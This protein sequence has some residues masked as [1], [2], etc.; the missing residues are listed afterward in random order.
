MSI[1]DRWMTALS[2]LDNADRLLGEVRIHGNRGPV[3]E[4]LAE[5]RAR[6]AAARQHLDSARDLR[7]FA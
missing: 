6:L 4:L 5:H 3:K 2:H 7:A 1:L